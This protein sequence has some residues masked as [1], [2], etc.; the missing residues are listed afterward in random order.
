MKH[1]L[2]YLLILLAFQVYAQRTHH[3]GTDAAA[4][5]YLGQQ[6]LANR[7][8]SYIESRNEITYL[9]VTFHLVAND[10]GIGRVRESNVLDQLCQLN[11]DFR[12]YDI[13]FY[14]QELNYVDNSILYETH[15]DDENLLIRQR[16]NAS[17]N[18]FILKE[19]NNSNEVENG[20]TLGYFNTQRDWLIMR[21]DQIN[22]RSIVLTHEVGHFLGLLHPYNGWDFE[23][24]T[25]EMHGNPAPTRSPRGISTER[26]DGSNCQQSGDFLCDTPPDYFFAFDRAENE[27]CEYQGGARDPDGV[28]VDP[29]ELNYMANFLDQCEREAYYFSEEQV[30]IMKSNIQSPQRDYLRTEFSPE[31]ITSEEEVLLNFPRDNETIP[32]FNLVP[33]EWSPVEGATQYLVEVDRVRSFNVQTRRVVTD[34]NSLE[35]SDLDAR[36]QY[37]WRVRPFNAYNTCTE[38]SPPSVFRTGL[39]KDTTQLPLIEDWNIAPNPV[40]YTEPLSIDIVTQRSF[41]TR[42]QVIDA[43]GRVVL[44]EIQFITP[45]DRQLFLDLPNLGVGAYFVVVQTSEARAVRKVVV[46]E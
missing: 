10:G 44:E 9:P 24:W 1:V 12:P 17:I 40:R 41:A 6:L 3:C 29:D 7:A 36:R 5:N 16:N 37:Y 35:L 18:V 14:L 45:S 38:F 39:V 32:T 4:L 30:A 26:M 11:I 21:R 31:R 23:P 20:R 46:V 22:D 28:L 25:E 43:L 34:Q 42:V 2:I 13:Q 33:L 27:D 19:A 8:I 15:R